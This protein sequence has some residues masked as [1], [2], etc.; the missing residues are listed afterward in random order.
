MPTYSLGQ[1]TEGAEVNAGLWLLIG[2]AV[3]IAVIAGVIAEERSRWQPKG[4]R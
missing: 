4:R 1:R 3:M 2:M